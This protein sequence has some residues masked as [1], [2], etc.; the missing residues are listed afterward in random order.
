MRHI[1]NMEAI[2]DYIKNKT[3]VV[4]KRLDEIVAEK[5]LP[6]N[7]LFQAARYSL[8]GGGKRLRPILALAT[9]EMCGES[10][11]NAL[12]PACALEMIHTYSLIH[13]DLPC[14][15][16]DD[17]RRGKPS[18][19][20]AFPEGHAVL[21]GDFLL[22]YAFEIITHAPSLSLQQKIELVRL[23]AKNSG[24]EGMIGGQIMDIESEGKSISVEFLRDIHQRKTGALINTAIQF[25]GVI[26]QVSPSHMGI[27]K[28]FGFE[29]GFAFQVIDDVLDVTSN[30][31]SDMKNNKFTF[32]TLLGLEKAKKLAETHYINALE[33]LE[34]LPMDTSLLRSI[35]KLLVYRNK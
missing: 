17:L 33:K 28:E 9:A 21:A 14:M 22:T 1:L 11:E 24:A 4:E 16:D 8:L 6:Y 23:L 30:K 2:E 29:L 20:K 13:D 27:L 34:K 5:N 18:L 3:S 12:D 32:V 7:S 26:A 31:N 15:D 19:H 10:P 35:A 25:G